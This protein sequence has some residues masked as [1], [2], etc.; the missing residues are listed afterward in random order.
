VVYGGKSV[1]LQTVQDF[2]GVFHVVM[3]CGGSKPAEL[4]LHGHFSVL[5]LALLLIDDWARDLLRFD[6][7][8]RE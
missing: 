2:L 4:L 8:A 5:A 1:L 7:W 6:N 3:L